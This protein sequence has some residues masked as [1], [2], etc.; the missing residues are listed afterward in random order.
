MESGSYAAC[1]SRL[2]NISTRES[3]VAPHGGKQKRFLACVPYTKAVGV[4]CEETND[5]YK[6]SPVTSIRTT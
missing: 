2:H 6:A 1:S 4:R 3:A 5:H